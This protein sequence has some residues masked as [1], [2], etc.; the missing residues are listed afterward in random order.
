MLRGRQLLPLLAIWAA[1]LVAQGP[2]ASVHAA[3]AADAAIDIGKLADCGTAGVLTAGLTGC[4]VAGSTSYASTKYYTFKTDGKGAYGVLFFLS[5]LQGDATMHFW[6]PGVDVS[7]GPERRSIYVYTTARTAE[8]YLFLEPSLVAKP[9]N[10]TLGIH[11]TVTAPSFLLNVYTPS[12]TQKLVTSE[13]EAL[14]EIHNLCCSGRSPSSTI[15]PTF[16][17]RDICAER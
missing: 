6:G 7:T 5:T 13:A 2:A 14:G 10:F 15:A 17:A 8:S 9:G 16:K 4:K 3:E 12:T 11:T 1:A